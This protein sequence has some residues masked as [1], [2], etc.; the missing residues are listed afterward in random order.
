MGGN[1]GGGASPQSPHLL[2]GSW[3]YATGRA[4]L[5]VFGTCWRIGFIVLFQIDCVIAPRQWRR[6]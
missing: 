6:C 5:S 2:Y 1:T 4:M 3:G